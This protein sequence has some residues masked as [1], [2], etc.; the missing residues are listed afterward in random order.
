M[1]PATLFVPALVGVPSPQLIET[2]R[3]LGLSIV[4]ASLKDA[5]EIAK[6]QGRGIVWLC[7]WVQFTEDFYQTLGEGKKGASSSYAQ[8]IGSSAD[9]L[10][11]TTGVE[12]RPRG[13]RDQLTR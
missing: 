2:P 12:L 1:G 13:C 6:G 9:E 4:F 10:L 8:P 7:R 5:K 11:D 3:L